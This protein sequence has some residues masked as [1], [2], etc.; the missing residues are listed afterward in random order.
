[1][2]VIL[3]TLI[4]YLPSP[5]PISSQPQNSTQP[6]IISQQATRVVVSS[7]SSVMNR[8]VPLPSIHILVYLCGNQALSYLLVLNLLSYFRK[9][10][11]NTSSTQSSSLMNQNSTTSSLSRSKKRSIRSSGADV[12]IPPISYYRPMASALSFTSSLYPSDPLI[13]TRRSNSGKSLN[14]L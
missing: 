13:Q 3:S 8:Y 2:I 9:R 14:V 1:M 5:Q 7:Y 6:V 11:V 4:I 12:R 10:A